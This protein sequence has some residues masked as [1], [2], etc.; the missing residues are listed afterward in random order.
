VLSREIAVVL[1]CGLV[2]SAAACGSEA[3][4]GVQGPLT[5]Y[6]SA[7]FRGLAG[8][9]GRDV[10]DG[11]ELALA[12][13]GGMAADVEVE[14]TYLDDTEG[15]GAAARWSPAAVA[16]NAR[17]A[18][19]DT[20][21]TAYIG[22]FES[23]AT[24][25]S[26]P[27]TNQAML[28]QVSAASSALDLVSDPEDE[29][30]P[31]SGLQPSGERTFLRVIPDDRVQAEAAAAW[32]R[33]S[34]VGVA[35]TLSDGTQFGDAVVDEFAE[36]ATGVGI[37][38]A[39]AQDGGELDDRTELVYV[40]GEGPGAVD[41]IRLAGEALPDAIVIST[42]AVLQEADQLQSVEPISSQ[43]RL[44]SSTQAAVELPP[45]GQTFAKAF[46]RQYGRAPGP[47]AAYGY[48]AM[49][50]VLDAIE[51][52]G[53]EAE[54]RRAVLDALLATSER[55]S[56]LGRYSI[57][58]LGNTTLETVAGYRIEGGRPVFDR[59]LDAP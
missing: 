46:T 58:A 35:A 36:A 47:Y 39:E 19:Q 55:D 17:E 59:A 9:D 1:A 14:A 4:D 5:V 11:A 32:A 42:D 13:A 22:D 57:T 10:R 20:S 15:S 33:R 24:R 25:V 51:R 23:G 53:P 52:A 26:L 37:E 49:A 2:G 30:A 16:A 29:G 12:D 6:V 56:V 7:P 50:L 38:V 34:N 21:A 43:L 44:T 3:D 8:P 27:I 41:Q 48:E 18:S 40:G 31:P 45:S 28:P 54:D